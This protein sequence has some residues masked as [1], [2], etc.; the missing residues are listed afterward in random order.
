LAYPISKALD[1]ILGD[2]VVAYD[3]K[4]L[5]ELMKLTTKNA[6]GGQA[7]EVRIALGAFEMVSFFVS[8]RTIIFLF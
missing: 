1:Y 4:R 2:E 3:R 7:D 5:M 6:I 8:F